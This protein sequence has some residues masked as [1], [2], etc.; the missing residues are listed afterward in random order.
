MK[1]EHTFGENQ[2]TLDNADIEV[3]LDTKTH[4]RLMTPQTVNPPSQQL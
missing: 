1:L 2:M 4:G 3:G